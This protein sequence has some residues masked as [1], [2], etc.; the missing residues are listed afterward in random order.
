MHPIRAVSPAPPSAAGRAESPPAPSRPPDTRPVWEQAVYAAARSLPSGRKVSRP[1]FVAVLLRWAAY[2]SWGSRGPGINGSPAVNTLAAECG[3][4]EKSI[5]RVLALAVEV[6]VLRRTARHNGGK[7][8]R[9]S[10]YAAAVPQIHTGPAEVPHNSRS[11]GTLDGVTRDL[12]DVHTGPLGVPQPH[13]PVPPPPRPAVQL[14]ILRGLEGGGGGEPDD[15]EQ[16]GN[17]DQVL[18]GIAARGLP[19]NGRQRRAIA[20]AVIAALEQ[21]WPVEQLIGRLVV[22]LPSPVRFPPSLLA[23]RLRELPDRPAGRAAAGLRRP[24]WCGSCHPDTRRLEHPGTGADAGMCPRC[25]T[26]RASG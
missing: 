2:A 20:P 10:T 7:S 17:V 14:P 26:L 25:T 3:C 19:L 1:V 22:D 21:G 16:S 15:D 4:S 13:D 8:P 11:H 24:A 5:D 18:D 12:C 23:V 9:P 6:D